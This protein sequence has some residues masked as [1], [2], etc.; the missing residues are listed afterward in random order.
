MNQ[1]IQTFLFEFN[2]TFIVQDRYQIFITGLKNTIT[3]A[4]FATLIGIVL[5]FLVA[6]IKHFAKENKKLKPLELLCNIYVTVIRGTPVVVQ[7]LIMYFI[8]MTNVENG[9]IIAI[10]TFG[11]NSGAYVSEIVRAGINAV[12]KGQMEAGASLGLGK[13]KIMKLIIVPQA[14]KNILPALGNEFISLLKETAVAGYVP[15]VDLTRAGAMIR[16]QTWS[17]F[18]PLLSV[19]A[20]YL[21]LV[22]GMTQLLKIAERRLSTSD[23]S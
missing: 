21:I 2:R 14:F 16:T 5:G 4:F 17:A 6:I 3:I 19:A 12:D 13:I 22:M 8:I 11:I 18:F 15:I 9:I 7:L 20:L 23:R 1:F 10:L